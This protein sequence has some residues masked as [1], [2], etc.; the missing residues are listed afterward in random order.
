MRGQGSIRV[1]GLAVA[2][3]VGLILVS[4]VYA[5]M[6]IPTGASWLAGMAEPLAFGIVTIT[7]PTVGVV[8][9][10]RRPSNLA[11]RLLCVMGL[12]WAL[13]NAATSFAN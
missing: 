4:F 8:V 13:A 5:G 1:Y 12:G 10:I 7:F 2:A 3:Q 6:A 11:G 9:L